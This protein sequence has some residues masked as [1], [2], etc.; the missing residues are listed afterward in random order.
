MEHPHHRDVAKLR[1]DRVA[2]KLDLALHSVQ[3]PVTP[4]STIRVP[5]ADLPMTLAE[6]GLLLRGLPAV[7]IPVPD[8]YVHEDKV[9]DSLVL[10][11]NE[12][13]EALDRA[14]SSRS[15][16]IVPREPLC[17]F[18]HLHLYSRAILS[19]PIFI[20]RRAIFELVDGDGRRRDSTLGFSEDWQLRHMFTEPIYL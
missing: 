12:Q 10:W 16:T 20:A 11:S 18:H 9:H 19:V 5:W 7:C 15:L 17:T 13:L 1:W 14:L 3:S 8:K 2:V 6:R 4:F